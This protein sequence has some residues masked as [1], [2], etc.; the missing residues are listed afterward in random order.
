MKRD[1]H[2]IRIPLRMPKRTTPPTSCKWSWNIC[3]NLGKQTNLLEASRS[4]R[5]E[6]K[7]LNTD[8][9]KPLLSY[10]FLEYN[11]AVVNV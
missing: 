6:G 8:F 2:H 3:V 10:P 1:K 7:W 9:L 5:T 11:S 4:F